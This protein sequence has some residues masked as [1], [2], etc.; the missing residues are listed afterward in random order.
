MDTGVAV[1]N[2]QM[3]PIF[4]AW[5]HWIHIKIT[6]FKSYH[7]NLL[8]LGPLGRVELHWG[9]KILTTLQRN[10]PSCW[11]ARVWRTLQGSTH[12]MTG[13]KPLLWCHATK[14]LCHA[15]NKITWTKVKR[16]WQSLAKVLLIKTKI[17][18]SVINL[19]LYW[20]AIYGD[21]MGT[22]QQISALVVGEMWGLRFLNALLSGRMWVLRFCSTE[23]RL[24]MIDSSLNRWQDGGGEEEN[25][26]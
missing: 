14:C 20:V 7:I 13:S 24:G 2:N 8:V 6:I 3:I 25:M 17:I 15:T 22:L 9:Q 10:W 23:R 16:V 21:L 4:R 1:V 11:L 12:G 26:F 5:I 19:A 18:Q